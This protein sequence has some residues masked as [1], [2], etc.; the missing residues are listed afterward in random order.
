MHVK[1]FSILDQSEFIIGK[2]CKVLVV[3]ILIG[4]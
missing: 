1:E 4:S 2:N 3:L